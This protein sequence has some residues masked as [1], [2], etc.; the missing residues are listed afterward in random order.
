MC[1]VYLIIA[2]N[3]DP[4]ALPHYKSFKKGGILLIRLYLIKPQNE[5]EYFRKVFSNKN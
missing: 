2:P 5:P 1:C 4:E 3:Y